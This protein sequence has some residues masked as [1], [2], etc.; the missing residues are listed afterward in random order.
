V[1]VPHRSLLIISAISLAS[2]MANLDAT[3]VFIALPTLSRTFAVD[4]SQVSWVVLAYLLA[5]CSFL[6]VFG[7]LGD[8][9]GA[10]RIFLWGYV[11]FIVT[12]FACGTAPGLASLV[13]L[14]TAQGLG[15][16]MLFATT[17]VVLVQHL[18]PQLHGRAFG[19][20][21]VFG[22][23][24]IALGTPIGGLLLAHLGWRWIFFV[25]VPFGLV[26]LILSARVL[27]AQPAPAAGGRFDLFGAASSLVALSSLVYALNMGAERG[28]LSPLILGCGLLAAASALY[29]VLHERRTAQP[30]LDLSLFRRA[31]LT[32]ALLAS[33]LMTVIL[34][35]FSFLFPFYFD[36][37]KGF[38]PDRIGLILA[39]FPVVSALVSPLAGA[40]A[41]RWR[42]RAVCLGA[43]VGQLG[44]LALFA[45]FGAETGYARL[46][47]SLVLYGVT[48][49]SF[50]CA[51]AALV[52]AQA[53]EGR[54]GTVSALLSMFQFTGSVFGVTGFET[55]YSLGFT[56][57]HRAGTSLRLGAAEVAAGYRRAARLGLGL[58]LAVVVLALF[59]RNRET[60]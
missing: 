28:W 23:M 57:Q 8:L 15:G 29:F 12:S 50:F 53:P 60:P 24:G 31:P 37:V 52:M 1:P 26:G 45:T 17:S 27:E 3:I 13:A 7:R 14:R 54:A 58:G 32:L 39:I 6:L 19:V 55:V 48:A 18:P 47:P 42:P 59:T 49:A 33:L 11:V 21:T 9:K 2:F 25:N 43:A 34:D 35:G 22:A 16:A 38:S 20:L 56:P 5:L 4:T 44:A 41:D 46:V 36:R 40:A 51:C 10:R 30:L